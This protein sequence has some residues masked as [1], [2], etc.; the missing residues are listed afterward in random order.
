MHKKLKV[1]VV[2]CGEITQISHLPYL[3]EIPYFEISA[4]CDLSPIVV[5]RLGEK[6]H[7]SDRFTDYNDLVKKELD[8]VLITNKNHAAP[9]IAAMETGKHVFVEKPIAFN[10]RQAED[11]IRVANSNKVKLLVGYMKRYDPAYEMMGKLIADLDKIHLIRVHGFAGTY[12]I[13]NEIY[14][15]IKASDLDPEVLSTAKQKDQVDL[16]ED[17]GKDRLDLLDAH[18]IMIH[19]CIHDINALHGLYGLPEKILCAHLFDSNFV[20]ALMQYRNGVNLMWESGNLITLVDWDEQITFF[21]SNKSLELRFPFPYLKNAATILNVR[22]NMEKSACHRQIITSYD[23]AFKREWRHFYD[24]I[25]YDKQP[26]TSAEE[27]KKDLKFAVEL[28]KAAA[29]I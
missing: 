20:T 15:L 10:L 7:V 27:A 12:Q 8:I 23:E 2:G 9:A 13:N 6:Y 26:S 22:E 28:T 24:C 17:I 25:V 29:R 14:D 5:D 19:L 4:L 3:Q 21:G 11:M 16:L 18:D 1:G